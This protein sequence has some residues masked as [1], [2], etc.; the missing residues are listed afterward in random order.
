MGMLSEVEES[1]Y[2]R[3]EVYLAQISYYSSFCLS[4]II[5]VNFNMWSFP[6]TR[7]IIFLVGKF[8]PQNFFIFKHYFCRFQYA[9]ISPR[10]CNDI[11]VQKVY[12]TYFLLYFHTDHVPNP[13]SNTQA[14]T[15]SLGHQE[16]VAPSGFQQEI[17]GYRDKVRKLDIV[18]TL[19]SPVCFSLSACFMTLCKKSICLMVRSSSASML[20]C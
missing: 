9:V 10:P 13:I 4:N 3:Q 14:R 7:Y 18:L 11:P 17:D 6:P 8:M 16:P 20:H 19:D 5:C 15:F 12:D 2:H 1:G